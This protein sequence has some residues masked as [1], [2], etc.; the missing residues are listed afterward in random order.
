M[1]LVRKAAALGLAG[2]R[3]DSN[4]RRAPD[5]AVE[6]PSLGR[7]PHGPGPVRGCAG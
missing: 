1:N 3:A 5:A 4:R 2:L 7:A 6:T